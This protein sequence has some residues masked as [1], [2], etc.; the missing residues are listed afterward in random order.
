MYMVGRKRH[1]EQTVVG[2]DMRMND[3][4]KNVVSHPLKEKRRWQL[5]CAYDK[6]PV[7]AQSDEGRRLSA[8]QSTFPFGGAKSLAGSAKAN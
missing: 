8:A 6:H 4:R 7:R 1:V 5:H 3:G 2:N